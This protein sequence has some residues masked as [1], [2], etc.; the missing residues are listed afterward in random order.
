[1]TNY[2]LIL[3]VYFADKQYVFRGGKTDGYNKL[4]WPDAS[5]KP[6]KA[7]FDRLQSEYEANQPIRDWQEQMAESD[8]VMTRNE[9]VIIDSMDAAQLSRLDSTIKNNHAAKKTLRGQ[10]PK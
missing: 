3:S 10:R 4:E 8:K 6:T 5:T 7:E 9:E 2:P 1:M